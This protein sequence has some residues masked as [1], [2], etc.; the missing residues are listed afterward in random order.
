MSRD[1]RSGS[2]DR[3]K[4][5]DQKSNQTGFGD[6]VEVKGEGRAKDDPRFLA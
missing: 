6:Y 5:T 1:V 4:Q 3:E 2:A